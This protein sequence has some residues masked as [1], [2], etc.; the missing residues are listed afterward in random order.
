[1]SSDPRTFPAATPDA[2]WHPARRTPRIGLHGLPVDWLAMA[3]ARHPY[4]HL[5]NGTR[6]YDPVSLRVLQPDPLSPFGAGGVNAYAFCLGDPVNNRD[7]SGYAPV[8]RAGMALSV[9]GLILSVL[10]FGTVSIL[11]S[12]GLAL[13]LAS[14][15]TGAASNLLSDTEADLAAM[16]G[17]ISLGLGISAMA[18]GLFQSAIKIGEWR[19]NRYLLRNP[20]ADMSLRAW[21][22]APG[23]QAFGIHGAPYATVSANRLLR[24]GQLVHRLRPLLQADT[25]TVLLGSCHAGQGGSLSSV[26]QAVANRLG[27]TVVASH[28]RT[29][30]GHLW[31]TFKMHALPHGAVRSLPPQ[32]TWGSLRTSLANTAMFERSASAAYLKH[33]FG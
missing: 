10:T 8:S 22:K 23:V 20:D 3:G 30:P 7:P 14:V 32:G 31:N 1:M 2:A 17:W 4:Y 26:G 13:A 6:S 5:G 25:R 11:A 28:D 33:L 15:A 21:S 9:V 19:F 27:K 16:L 29:S 18:L 12:L 24:A